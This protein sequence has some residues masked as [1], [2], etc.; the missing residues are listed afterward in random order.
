MT[1]EQ[2]AFID[3]PLSNISLRAVAGSG[4]TTSIVGRIKAQGASARTLCLAFNRDIAKTLKDRTEGMAVCAT[5]NSL[6]HRA[7][8][9]V[10]Q[11]KNFEEDNKAYRI[12]RD[13]EGEHNFKETLALLRMARSTG[14]VPRSA[15]PGALPLIEDTDDNWFALADY[16]DIDAT[17]KEISIAREAMTQCIIDAWRGSIDYADQIYMPAIYG[18]QF[19]D[20]D[21]VIIDEAQ[22]ISPLQRAM[23]RRIPH[24]ALVAVGDPNQAIYGWRGADTDSMDNLAEEWH[25]KEMPLSVS[26]RCPKSVVREAQQYVPH[27]QWSDSAPEGKVERLLE[28]PSSFPSG[29]AILCRNNKPIISLAF[30]LIRGG[31]SCRVVGRDIGKSLSK[32]VLRAEQPS[33]SALDA[34]L[35]NYKNDEMAKA[36]KKNRMSKVQAIEDRVESLR[37]VM[38]MCK[39]VGELLSMLDLMFGKTTARIT[40][41]TIHRAKGLEWNQVYFLD[42]WL[43]PNQYAHQDWQLQQED[44]LAYVGV[45][46]AMSEL[47]F[48][49]SRD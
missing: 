49:N 9:G 16:H 31:E 24:R 12:L 46:R 22:D 6:G 26:F 45:T 15:P 18:G 28:Q 14:L 10:S 40:L 4:K 11:I 8:N 1:P 32:L 5:T 47:Y 38:P 20:F 35:E 42:S 13:L 7:W 48:I 23:L 27:M 2:Q 41:S 30:K 21:Q 37:A 36:M 33:I 17:E 39:S 3:E 19:S 25:Q 44:N 34:W 29:S 43:L